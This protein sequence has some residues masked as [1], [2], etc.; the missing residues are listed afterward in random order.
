M[1]IQYSSMTFLLFNCYMHTA[2]FSKSTSETAPAVVAGRF[3]TQLQSLY[4]LPS[5]I[6]SKLNQQKAVAS[7]TASVYQIRTR[8][9]RM[10]QCHVSVGRKEARD[11]V[12]ASPGDSTAIPKSKSIKPVTYDIVFLWNVLILWTQQRQSSLDEKCRYLLLK[13]VYFLLLFCFI[14]TLATYFL[15]SVTV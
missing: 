3:V 1:H 7:V 13:T 4:T 8:F 2:S 15:S 14:V 6:Q 9:Y 10:H 11:R 5:I 12:R